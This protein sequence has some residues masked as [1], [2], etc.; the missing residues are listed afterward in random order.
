MATAVL[1][2]RARLNNLSDRRKFDD[3]Y[4][5]EHLPSALR[6]FRAQR[7]WRCWSRT[8]PLVHLALYEFPSVEE[9]EAILDS[10]ALASQIAEF[11]RYWGTEVTRT[12]EIVEVAEELS[13]PAS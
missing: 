13:A 10:Q 9:A 3:W 7:A 5:T 8:N 12:R 2:V 1:I 11:D 6:A 4:R